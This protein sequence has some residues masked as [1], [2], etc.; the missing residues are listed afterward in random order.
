MDGPICWSSF[1]VPEKGHTLTPSIERFQSEVQHLGFSVLQRLTGQSFQSVPKKKKK[2]RRWSS[3]NAK[4][5]GKLGAQV[6]LTEIANRLTAFVVCGMIGSR[7]VPIARSHPG[8]FISR[9][10]VGPRLQ[11]PVT[12]F[13]FA[14]PMASECQ[15]ADCPDFVPIQTHPFLW[16]PASLF[17]FFLRGL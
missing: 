14:S 1:I 2:R 7:A 4:I 10:F 8:L 5:G 16:T 3:H 11:F 9:Q 6:H 15:C 13:I 12:L 17:L